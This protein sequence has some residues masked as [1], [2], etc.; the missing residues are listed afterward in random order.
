MPNDLPSH[1]PRPSHRTRAALL[2][3]ALA[4]T[5]PAFAV[6]K[7]MVQL[8]TQIQELQ[9]A[10][11]RLQQS[12]DE[13]M[14][15][16]KDLVQQS[17][18]SVNKMSLN[19]DALEKQLHTQQ[20]A[21][22]GKLDQV[23][24]QVQ[25]LS[26]SVDE[27]KARL[28]HLEKSLADVQSQ[29]Q[30]I[31]ASI[32]NLAPAAAAPDTTVSGGPPPTVQPTV[33]PPVPQQAPLVNRRGK[34]APTVPLAA[35]ATPAPEPVATVPTAPLAADLFNAA[36]RDYMAAKYSLA[37]SEFAEVVRTYPDDPYAGNAFYYTGE[38]DYRAGKFAAAVKDYDRVLEQFPNSSKIAVAQL[39][40]GMALFS[41]KQNDAGIRE[42]RA[43]IARFPSS[44]E[45]ASARSKLN[46]M[47]VPIVPK[48]HP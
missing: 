11:A 48:Q 22:G 43:L 3:V 14:G 1:P 5:T 44:P 16:L 28:N 7:D 38:I 39:H 21:T 29:Q 8:Q 33:P 4:L 2:A 40:K 17:A 34:P 32:L 25:A 30:S 31:N 36:L 23:S 9:D 46:G 19:I 45:A 35:A 26:D 15:V 37:S 10:L 24:S 41:L 12:N 6:N 47:G 27:I 42:L 13:R 20:E 18:D